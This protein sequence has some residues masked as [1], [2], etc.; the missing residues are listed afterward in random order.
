MRARFMRLQ[1]VFTGRFSKWNDLNINALSTLRS[2]FDPANLN[3][4]DQFILARK[5]PNPIIRLWH[6]YK[7]GVSRQTLLGNLGLVMAT[8]FRKF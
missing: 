8:I 3:V 5:S 2:R 7:S 4:L 1:L 6:L